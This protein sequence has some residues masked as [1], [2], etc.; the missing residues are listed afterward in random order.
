MCGP[1]KYLTQG[2]IFFTIY[3]LVDL[4]IFKHFDLG[5]VLL[6]TFLYVGFTLLVDKL[7][8]R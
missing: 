3:V 1:K 4:L 2:I 8:D 7:F 6:A 5:N